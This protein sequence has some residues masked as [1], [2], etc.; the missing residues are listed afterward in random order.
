MRGSHQPPI[1][2]GGGGALPNAGAP[3][4]P[5]CL[6]ALA[7]AGRPSVFS[8]C[9]SCHARGRVA[10]RSPTAGDAATLEALKHGMTP[11]PR[12]LPQTP[13]VDGNQQG[14]G[15]SAAIA[16]GAPA[17]VATALPPSRIPP[18][19]H[20]RDE[21]GRLVFPSERPAGDAEVGLLADT[22]GSM[23]EEWRSRLDANKPQFPL[24]AARWGVLQMCLYDMWCTIE[25][26]RIWDIGLTETE[27]LAHFYSPQLAAMLG[28][29]RVRLSQAFAT[30]LSMS[31]R[32]Q[33][34]LQR[35]HTQWVEQSEQLKREQASRQSLQ[36]RVTQLQERVASLEEELTLHAA[37]TGD[38]HRSRRPFSSCRRSGRS[39]KE[40]RA[41]NARNTSLR[42]S[43]L[44]LR[45]SN[46]GLLDELSRWRASPG[47]RPHKRAA[48]QRAPPSH[49]RR[50]SSRSSSSSPRRRRRRVRCTGAGRRCRRG[51]PAAADPAL[52]LV[53]C[54]RAAYRPRCHPSC[55]RGAYRRALTERRP[56]QG[57]ALAN[58]GALGLG[59][60]P[61]VP[62]PPSAG[63]LARDG[64]DGR[65]G[66]LEQL[67]STLTDDEAQFLIQQIAQRRAS[68]EA[69]G[70]RDRVDPAT[71]S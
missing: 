15:S 55:Q 16:A 65:L 5:G 52:F 17:Q 49:R 6:V 69:S 50:R 32:M 64:S 67:A 3:N 1:P 71:V 38:A 7:R 40:L 59:D 28:R 45:L 61:R 42:T 22:L 48:R 23:L 9:C 4:P 25:E 21:V 31:Q 12:L 24:G 30:T 51:R 66:A 35:W 26:A 19:F 10:R 13:S 2:R 11:N 53:S 44:T 18:N 56:A 62:V 58:S 39:S 27:R 68:N 46:E 14:S 20:V 54:R 34:E 47:R 33:F 8:C 36:F 41:A 43:S 60:G 70:I 29:L 57:S 63:E 37:R